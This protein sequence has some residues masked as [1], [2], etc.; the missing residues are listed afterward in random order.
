MTTVQY[1]SPVVPGPPPVTLEMPDGWKQVWAPET[2]IA[3]RQEETA[4]GDHFLANVVV[5]FFQRVAPF[6]PEQVEAELMEYA[7]SKPEGEMGPLKDQTIDGRQ[8]VGA[9]LAFTD[10]RAGTIGQVH[11]FTA[12][13]QNDVMDVIQV[14]GSYAGARQETDY[15]TIDAV[16]D[17][18]RIGA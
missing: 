11:W 14:T 13:A 7:R 3:I 9:D 5:R 2:L 1:P 4:D 6:G 12:H 10:E 18:V 17:S 8:W 16:V 15:A